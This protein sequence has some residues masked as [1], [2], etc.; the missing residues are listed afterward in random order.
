MEEKKIKVIIN[1]DTIELF[2]DNP[3]IKKLVEIILK[4]DKDFD[5]KKIEII[6]SDEKFDKENFKS[7]LINSIEE[8]KINIKVEEQNK[9]E[10]AEKIEQLKSELE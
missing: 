5:F 8:F 7:I 3:D 6:C 1:K 4:Q 10:K 2:S 9:K